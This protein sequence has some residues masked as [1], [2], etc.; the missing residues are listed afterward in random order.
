M[1]S[2]LLGEMEQE[3]KINDEALD[4]ILIRIPKL[5]KRW[6]DWQDKHRES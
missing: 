6:D 3:K 5:R 2:A 4:D 1:G